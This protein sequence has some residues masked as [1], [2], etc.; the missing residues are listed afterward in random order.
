MLKYSTDKLPPKEGQAID[1]EKEKKIPGD[2][3]FLFI[4]FI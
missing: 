3:L 4:W 2:F 1:F